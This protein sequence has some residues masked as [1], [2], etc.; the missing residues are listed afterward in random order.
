MKVIGNKYVKGI[1]QYIQAEHFGCDSFID[2]HRATM[3]MSVEEYTA[4]Y[5]SESNN[6]KTFEQFSLNEE[7]K[8][9]SD[10]FVPAKLRRDFE[11]L[12]ADTAIAVDALDYSKAGKDDLVVCY[13]DSSDEMVRLKKAMIELEDGEGV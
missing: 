4:F 6:I 2:W 11:D 7:D 10:G 5:L 12:K 3:G 13:L 8:S 9:R 1:T